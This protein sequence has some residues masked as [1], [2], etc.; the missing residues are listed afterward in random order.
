MQPSNNSKY[1]LLIMQNDHVY[2]KDLNTQNSKTFSQLFHYYKIYLY[3]LS[4]SLL[5]L[6]EKV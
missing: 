2:K 4:L 3:V 1:P 6:K 5:F